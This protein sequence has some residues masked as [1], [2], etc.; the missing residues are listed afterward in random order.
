MAL[1]RLLRFGAVLPALL[2]GTLSSVQPA[3]AQ[4]LFEL[5]FGAAPGAQ[6][7]ATPRVSKRVA[8]RPPTPKWS[9]VCVRLCDGYFF[10]LSDNVTRASFSRDEAACRS[11]CASD[12]RFFYMPRG[13]SI[14]AAVDT[15]GY[16]YASL[17]N[18][19][20]YRQASVAGCACR[21]EPWAESE[22]KRHASYAQPPAT[23]NA[24]RT[25]Q[26]GGNVGT[27][28]EPSPPDLKKPKAPVR[29]IAKAEPR[30][31]PP[32]P[33]PDGV[34]LAQGLAVGSGPKKTVAIVPAK[35][36]LGSL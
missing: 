36:I 1:L 3:S 9:T 13:K 24:D 20:R 34:L 10:P 23:E 21:P 12:A 16:S 25:S 29:F 31:A 2:F 8:P 35:G 17:A 15:A 19:Y 26:G 7:T 30:R 11:L 5:L 4:S 27:V 32:R 28:P 18:A 14:D 22:M 33:K 6:P